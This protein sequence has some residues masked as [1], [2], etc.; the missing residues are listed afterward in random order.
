MNIRIVY[1]AITLFII[2]LVAGCS[3]NEEQ[4][5]KIEVQIRVGNEAKYEDFKEVI[6]NEQVVKVKR[7]L[8]DTDWEN[9]VVDMARLAD[10]QF[11]FEYMNKDIEG[12]K[13]QYLVWISP[14]KDKLEVVRGN[15]EYAQLTRENSAILFEGITGKKLTDVE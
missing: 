4:K 9:T 8:D 2:F 3:T 1:L 5:Q 6:D 13:L 12:D 10:Y 15:D 7:I 14:N 11:F